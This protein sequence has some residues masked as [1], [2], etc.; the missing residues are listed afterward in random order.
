[1]TTSIQSTAIAHDRPTSQTRGSVAWDT[2]IPSHMWESA[3]MAEALASRDITTVYKILQSQ[4]VSQRRIAHLT[5]QSQPEIAEIIAGRRVRSYDV[6]CRIF[7]GL[8]APTGLPVLSDDGAQPADLAA[9]SRQ[10]APRGAA[11][12]DCPTPATAASTMDNQV[13][14]GA[15]PDMQFV[16]VPTPAPEAV[17]VSMATVGAILASAPPGLSGSAPPVVT[18][19]TG[20]HI[21]V[22]RR[23]KHQS[24]RGFAARLGVSG[25]MV[26]KWEAGGIDLRPRAT[27]QQALD[28]YLAQSSPDEHSRFRD[29][30]NAISSTVAAR[31]LPPSETVSGPGARYELHLPLVCSTLADATTIAAEVVTILSS[32][33]RIHAAGTAIGVKYDPTPP[34][35]AL[36]NPDERRSQ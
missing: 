23:A 13:A 34:R 18:L 20:M 11:L 16:A 22:L 30:M 3:G 6:L 28:T 35:Q 32:H 12:E 15:P 26:S 17:S 31:Q 1:M 29:G 25:R 4:R 5:G 7:T 24:V 10:D 9:T 33:P 19:W 36:P 14:A 8:G 27:N 2:P 21:R